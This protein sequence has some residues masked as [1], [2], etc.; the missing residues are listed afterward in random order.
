MYSFG[1]LPSD[2]NI[3]EESYNPPPP[4]WFRPESGISTPE[5]AAA[6]WYSYPYAY[7]HSF[8]GLGDRE[9]EIE[10]NP[11]EELREL[12]FQQEMNKK[13]PV[14]AN[15]YTKIDP[16]SPL[17]RDKKAKYG[18]GEYGQEENS[19]SMGGA[20]MQ[21]TALGMTISNFYHGYRRND[22][23]LLWGFLWILLGPI[24]VALSLAQGYGQPLA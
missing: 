8:S 20:V 4:S 17:F 1:E 24:G 10:V 15:R 13:I 16:L 11:V 2:L 19:I 18:Y 9:A 23:S 22:G 14:Q 12:K 6:A 3:Q 21:L 7:N 5:Q